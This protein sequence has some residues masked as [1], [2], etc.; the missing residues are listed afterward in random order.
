MI[1][2][3]MLYAGAAALLLTL[4]AAAAERAARALGTATRWAWLGALVLSLLGPA[5]GWWWGSRAAPAVPAATAV[6]DDAASPD[7]LLA[8]AEA[9][10]PSA[11]DALLAR[12]TLHVAPG[13]AWSALDGPLGAVWA[14]GSLALLISLALAQRRLRRARRE[15]RPAVVGGARVLV[16]GRTGPAVAGVWR[17]AVVLPEWALAADAALLGLM[18]AHEREHQRAGDPRLLALA[19]LAVALQPWNPALWYQRRRLRLAVE[20]DCDRRVLR[21]HPDVARYGA[22]LLE[23][24]RRAG[25]PALPLAALTSTTSSLE[26]RIRIM[27][28]RRPRHALAQGTA[29]LTAS[30]LV[31]TAALAM[32]R[33]AQP[34]VTASGTVSAAGERGVRRDLTP[35]QVIAA[36]REAIPQLLDEET[37][38]VA[39]VYF[40]LDADGR[41]VRA[42]FDR[43]PA[44]ESPGATDAA[45]DPS[46]PR[47][48]MLRMPDADFLGDIDPGAIATVDVARFAP[49]RV[50]PDS[51]DVVWVQ[52]RSEAAVGQARGS[53]AASATTTRERLRADQARA[54]RASAIARAGGAGGTGAVS[55]DAVTTIHG[56]GADV[57]VR[58]A[59]AQ[60]AAAAEGH[61]PIYVI[62][63][64]VV[65]PDD[66]EVLRYLPPETI[67]NIE[68]VKGAAAAALY[69][70]QARGG[71]VSITTRPGAASAGGGIGTARSGTPDR[72]VSAGVAGTV[73]GGV[74]GGS[75]G[76]S[77]AT[78]GDVGSGVSTAV[79]GGVGGTVRVRSGATAIGGT[80]SGISG[81]VTVRRA[82][83]AEGDPLYV[84]DGVI[85]D[86]DDPAVRD[87][88]PERIQSVEVLKGAAATSTYGD[89]AAHGVIKI[90]TKASTIPPPR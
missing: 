78:S 22:L 66:R 74:R 2:A 46:Q 12:A 15:W 58:Q 38:M 9:G 89:R 29:L 54:A 37:G 45:A 30:A 70:E 88:A 19:T 31:A 21:R 5:A 60:A 65:Q 35:E 87:L 79:S 61:A 7:A 75:G 36:I 26:R 40:V 52:L 32:P 67:D 76:V 64:I 85:V 1:A 33:P 59:V 84:I 81:G 16:A 72:G 48:A 43:H 77:T 50:I 49:G 55:T 25:A 39:T 17:T 20:V 51:A 71:V 62:D 57:A 18:L 53:D 24:G 82:P 4:A 28:M 42:R 80:A 56:A 44:A 10:S 86:A 63:G 8:L 90:T 83:G 69:G 47:A 14:A 13:A 11:F 73:S 41:I 68:V 27:T 34:P 6:A 23:V 3:W